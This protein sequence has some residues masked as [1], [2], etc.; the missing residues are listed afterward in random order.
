MLFLNREALSIIHCIRL[1]VRLS[2]VL[3]VDSRPFVG[4]SVANA[5]LFFF[6]YYRKF[7]GIKKL[8]EIIYATFFS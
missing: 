1:S 4:P 2:V 8:F 5:F 7:R 3:T 6:P